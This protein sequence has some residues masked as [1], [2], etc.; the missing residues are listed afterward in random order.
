MAPVMKPAGSRGTPKSRLRPRAAPMNSATSVAIAMASAC[1]QRNQVSGPRVG[2]P[3][4]L[5]QVLVG[6]DAE[7]GREV[8]HE[9]G[10]EVGHEHDPEQQVAE[11]GAAGDVGGEVA[12][13]DVGDGGD[14]GGPEHRQRGAH[15]AAG[16]E[17]LERRG[18]RESG[19][20]TGDQ[21]ARSRPAASWL[22]LHRQGAR[23]QAGPGCA[24]G[25]RATRSTSR[26]RAR[27]PAPRPRRRARR[28][29]VEVGEQRRASASRMRTRR[30]FA[31]TGSRSSETASA[32]STSSSAEGMGSPCGS[33]AGSPSFAAM[34][35][36]SLVRDSVLERLGLVV[37]LVPAHAQLA[38]EVRLEQA[39]ATHDA[40]GSPPARRR[41][42]DAA[43]ARVADQTVACE[44]LHHARHGGGPDPE[45]RGQLAGAHRL[46][47]LRLEEVDRLQV[48]LDGQRRDRLVW[49]SVH[50]FF[51]AELCIPKTITSGGLIYGGVV[52][53]EGTTLRRHR[54][55][56]AWAAS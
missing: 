14:E 20:R 24:C 32:S 12:G 16:E 36:R 48:V 50:E 47:A 4:E 25:R 33:R 52:G 17:L 55:L 3:A 9:H 21:G 15:T 41:Q 6:D 2:G 39:M 22:D 37:D 30:P 27:R 40:Q 49:L 44:A 19:R 10:H 34:A 1:S 46:T 42:L 38:H 54:L 28:P 11:L 45:A 35:A 8:L 29:A 26:R 43:V 18:Q 56:A 5:G 7:L 53:I 51:V 13:V 31:P 23:P